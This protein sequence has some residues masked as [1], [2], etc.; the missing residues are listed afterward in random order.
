M[1]SLLH[2]TIKTW[3]KPLGLFLICSLNYACAPSAVEYKDIDG[4]KVTV[5]NMANLDASRVEQIKFSDLADDIEVVRLESPDP[6]LIEYVQNLSISE[7]YILIHEGGYQ[8]PYKLFDRQGRFIGQ[9]GSVG[10]GPLEYRSV[11]DAQMSETNK[12]IYLMP[13]SRA[14]EI[15]CYNLEGKPLR[16]LPLAHT[17]IDKPKF[18][19]D[20]NTITVFQLPLGNKSVV[21][22]R[23]DM[24]GQLIDAIPALPHTHAQSYDD[25]IFVN[26]FDGKNSLNYTPIDTLFV[27][28]AQRNRL[29]PT[30][31]AQFSEEPAPI[32]SYAEWPGY[33]RVWVYGHEKSILVDKQAKK[34]FHFELINDLWGLPTQSY[35]IRDNHFILIYDAHRLLELIEEHINKPEISEKA[36]QQMKLLQ[37]QLDEE[38]NPIL[39]IGKLKAKR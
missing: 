4:H 22:F 27:Y 15:L 39:L 31:Y 37:T 25:E 23:Q 26:N 12:E 7:N 16:A 10:N 17:D 8:K 32:H 38:D 30:F 13:F 29:V 36:K 24:Q 19:I 1:K 3:A 33:Y 5:L 28:N 35:R 9:V 6:A 11:S 14:Q 18:F 2:V 21:A 20:N 34:A